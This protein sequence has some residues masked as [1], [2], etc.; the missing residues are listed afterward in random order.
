MDALWSSRGDP[1]DGLQSVVLAPATH[2]GCLVTRLLVFP[3]HGARAGRP[4]CLLRDRWNA[5]FVVCV[6]TAVKQLFFWAVSACP[7]AA[8]AL[9]IDLDDRAVI[10]QPV[11]RCH[12]HGT[13]GE[14]VL[15]LAER[16]VRGDQ[17]RPAYGLRPNSST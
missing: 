1:V 17:Q 9:A 5:S 6:S 14:D 2:Y 4:R 3:A 11:H 10:H 8:V 15:P 13:G 12:C 7:L 16:L